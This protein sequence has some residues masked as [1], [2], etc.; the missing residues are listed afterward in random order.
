[1]LSDLKTFAYKGC[2]IA[3]PKMVCFLANFALL[4]EFFSI[5]GTIGICRDSLSPIRGI[6]LKPNSVSG[7]GSKKNPAN[8]PHLVDKRLTPPPPD[9]RWPKLIIFT[10]RNFF[11]YIC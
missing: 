2:K 8:Y 9:P 11:I 5:G 1:M 4:A 6:F 7:K 10:L 3:T